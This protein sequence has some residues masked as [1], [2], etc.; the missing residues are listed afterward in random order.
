MSWKDNNI[1][2]AKEIAD[3]TLLGEPMTNWRLHNMLD[4]LDISEIRMECTTSKSNKWWYI[5]LAGPL[6][7]TAWGKI[8][9]EGNLKNHLMEDETDAKTYFNKKVREKF[10]KSYKF[11]IINYS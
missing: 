6:V 1:K 2:H 9:N 11:K 10:N 3:K 5:Q 7:A 4:W 8:G